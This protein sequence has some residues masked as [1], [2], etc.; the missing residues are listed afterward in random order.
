MQKT[1]T[2]AIAPDS[3][4]G[5]LTAEQAAQCIKKGFR[6]G[7]PN[8]EYRLIPMADGGEGTVAAMTS[9]T[10]GRLVYVRVCGPLG[11]SVRAAFG[12]TGD[13]QTA[14]IE[15]AAASGL[16]LLKLSERN[17]L[18]TS[19][20]GTGELIRKALDLGV[21]H[22]VIGIGGSA[23]VDGGMGMARALGAKYLDARGREVPEGGGALG[24]IKKIDL[25]NLDARLKTVRLDVACDVTNP[26]VGSKGAA[27]V[28]GPQKGATPAM[29]KVLDAG[30]RNLSAVIQ[31]DLGMLVR[32]IPGSGAAG[33]LGAGL[34]AFLGAKL[35]RGV[36]TVID[37]VG[38]KDRLMGCDLVVTGEGRMDAQTAYGKT[39][40]GVAGVAR[41]LK[42]PVVAICGCVGR[43]VP[44]VRGAG[45]DVYFSALQENMAP[46][47]VRAR[48]AEMLGDCAA[49]VA[50][51]WRLGMQKR[52]ATSRQPDF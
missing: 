18:K 43:D 35:K 42:I 39:P 34:L 26:L 7:F 47:D 21:K 15:M 3:F 4:K 30:L 20:C 41:R 16:P 50:F 51:M 46:E 11:R 38:L 52:C 8:A 29:V 19:T 36:T 10:N 32:D 2:I 27:E 24:R 1:L 25:S 9:A 22:M 6:R 12:V 17:P 33:G 5:S 37:T 28:Y 23:T 44:Q 48:A 49:Q 13:G 40:A 14:V 45:I 31:R